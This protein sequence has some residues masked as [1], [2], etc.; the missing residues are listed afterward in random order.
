MAYADDGEDVDGLPNEGVEI[1]FFHLVSFYGPIY[2]E[3]NLGTKKSGWERQLHKVNR[4]SC[5]MS[6]RRP[7]SI[8]NILMIKNV[9]KIIIAQYLCP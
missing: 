5:L 8:V 6:L 9:P 3:S 4:H 2:E 1:T 7:T